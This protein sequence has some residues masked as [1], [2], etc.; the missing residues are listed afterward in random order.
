MKE[1]HIAQHVWNAGFSTSRSAPPLPPLPPLRGERAGVRGA[2]GRDRIADASGLIVPGNRE[3]METHRKVRTRGA[4]PSSQP[5]LPEEGGEGAC[6]DKWKCSVP[7]AGG[8]G[9]KGVSR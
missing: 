3:G 9:G 7:P 5:S 8:G 6:C 1:L 2:C 4:P